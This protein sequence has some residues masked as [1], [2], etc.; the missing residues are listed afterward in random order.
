TLTFPSDSL[1]SISLSPS[2]STLLP[3][4]KFQSHLRRIRERD[5]AANH[6]MLSSNIKGVT[7][8][9]PLRI[10]IE[11]VV[12]KQVDFNADFLRNMFPKIEWKAL[13]GAAR[14]LGYVEL[15]EEVEP[16]RLILKIF[17][18]SSIMPFWSFISRRV[19][20]FAPRLVAGFRFLRE[21]PICYFMK[22]KCESSYGGLD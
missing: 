4:A 14:T 9:F 16:S 1:Y 17:C 6:N 2:L 11:K 13:V 3:A 21:Y 10:E 19:R 15:P 12:E 18:A 5:E 20:L 7:N 8:G 22:T